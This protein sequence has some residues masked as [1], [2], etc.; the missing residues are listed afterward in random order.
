MAWSLLSIKQLKSCKSQLARQGNTV[1]ILLQQFEHSLLLIQHKCCTFVKCSVYIY[2]IFCIC[3]LNI[4]YIFTTYLVFILIYGIY[5]IYVCQIF[6][7]CLVDI[8]YMFVRYLVYVCQIIGIYLLHIQY[9]FYILV[10][11]WNMF[12]K[13]LVY[14]Y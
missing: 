7:I 6:G 4:R 1:G 9:L 10:Y 5:L 3:L 14:I 13:Y 8:W 12:V 11:I 2:Y